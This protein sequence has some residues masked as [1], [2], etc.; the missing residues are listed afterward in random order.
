MDIFF[1]GIDDFLL[2]ESFQT[3][4]SD[5]E[6]FVRYCQARMDRSDVAQD[7]ERRNSCNDV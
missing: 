6:T 2:W 7:I 5:D 1:D 3:E 4:H